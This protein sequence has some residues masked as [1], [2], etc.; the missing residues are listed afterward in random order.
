MSNGILL[1]QSRPESP[2]ALADFHRWY[3]EVHLPQILAVDGFVS[4]RRLQSLDGE[5]FLAV[6][7]VD[8]DVEQAKANFAAARAAGKVD[9][10]VGVQ[11]DPPPSAQ[12]FRL[13]AT[14]G[15]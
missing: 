13:I 11:L 12:W 4:A 5:S 6:Y 15:G 8:G 2:E 14:A 9:D 10:P 3:D 1:V 7:E